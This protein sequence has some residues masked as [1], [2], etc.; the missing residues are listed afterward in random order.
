MG[1]CCGLTF[2]VQGN[3]CAVTYMLYSFLPIFLSCYLSLDC[4]TLL[5]NTVTVMIMIMHTAMF[6]YFPAMV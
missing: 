5:I 2:Y 4:F 3:I 6:M 1:K